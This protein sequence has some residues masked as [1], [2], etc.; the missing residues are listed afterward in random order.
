MRK[1]RPRESLKLARQYIVNKRKIL[2]PGHSNF[3]TYT[4]LA[5]NIPSKE[6]KKTCLKL[7]N[8]THWAW[9]SLLSD[10]TLTFGRTWT[11]SGL[12]SDDVEEIMVK[13]KRREVFIELGNI[14]PLYFQ[15]H[16]WS[17][18]GQCLSSRDIIEA[19]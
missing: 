6:E 13:S 4:F 10:P 8:F 16:M 18:R 2:M 9:W 3:K 7:E 1:L 19:K 5:L 14:F 12:Y 11:G 15:E 17:H